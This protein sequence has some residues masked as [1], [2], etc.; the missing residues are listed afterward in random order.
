MREPSQYLINGSVP[1]MNIDSGVKSRYDYNVWIT[2]KVRKWRYKE[3]VTPR[4]KGERRHTIEPVFSTNAFL[5]P[6]SLYS[7]RYRLLFIRPLELSLWFCRL[8][9][10]PL[11]SINFFPFLQQSSNSF[12]LRLP[13]LSKSFPP[14]PPCTWYSY[15]FIGRGPFS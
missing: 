5:L 12:L 14:K 13:N 1:G 7:Q 8:I 4:N 10:F 3:F 15:D 11:L 9:L 6:L 2:D